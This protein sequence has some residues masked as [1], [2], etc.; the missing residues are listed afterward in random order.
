VAAT[1]NVD[2]AQVETVRAIL[3]DHGVLDCV[4][5][6]EWRAFAAATSADQVPYVVEGLQTVGAP[7]LSEV[8]GFNQWY[9]DLEPGTTGV[10]L[11]WIMAVSAG[12]PGFGGGGGA[13]QIELATRAGEPVGLEW[14]R[15]LTITADQRIAV[16]AATMTPGGSFLQS[17]TLA[18]G[19][20]PPE[21]G[22]LY[23]SMLNVANDAASIVSMRITVHGPGEM[24]PEGVEGLTTCGVP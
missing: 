14:G 22:R 20:L 1:E 10:E 16:A 24:L 19:C 7:G 2:A 6:K 9:I 8:P 3:I 5:A 15:G 4:R 12:I 17:T 21:G 11:S 18:G 23:L 13:G